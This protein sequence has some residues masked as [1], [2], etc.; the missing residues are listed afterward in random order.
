MPRIVEKLKRVGEDREIVY[1]IGTVGNFAG[2]LGR[3][4]TGFRWAR[5]AIRSA[6]EAK[7][8]SREAISCLYLTML[9]GTKGEL[10]ELL[11]YSRRGVELAEHVGDRFTASI[12]MALEGYFRYVLGHDQEGIA[13]QVES[14]EE[15]RLR[16]TQSLLGLHYAQ[17]AE[18][19]ALAGHPNR[20]EE[21]AELGVV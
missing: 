13:M 7:D 17:L 2:W 20:A 16:G 1:L 6:R 9:H 10:S 8:P 19:L 21:F 3:F 15:H 5:Q 14:L 11:E 4:E 18:C 12:T